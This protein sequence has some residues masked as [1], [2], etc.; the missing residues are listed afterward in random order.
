MASWDALETILVGWV[1][2]VDGQHIDVDKEMDQNVGLIV[3]D[4][5][6]EFIAVIEINRELGLFGSSPRSGDSGGPSRLV[7]S[8]TS[9]GVPMGK[10]NE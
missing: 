7:N 10:P 1:V 5:V 3:E 6:F 2:R 8:T 4:E 9:T